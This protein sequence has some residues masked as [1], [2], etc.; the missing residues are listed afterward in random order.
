MAQT[1]APR[2]SK[3]FDRKRIHSSSAK[4][5][6]TREAKRMEMFRFRAKNS[7]VVFGLL[8]NGFGRLRGKLGD[9]NVVGQRHAKIPVIAR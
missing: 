3:Y 7:I 1:A 8:L 5:I 4:P 9:C 2:V 6:P